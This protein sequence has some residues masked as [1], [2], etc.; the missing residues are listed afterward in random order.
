MASG[1]EQHGPRTLPTVLSSPELLAEWRIRAVESGY[2]QEIEPGTLEGLADAAPVY[3]LAAEDAP[4][5]VRMREFRI[6]TVENPAALSA[7]SGV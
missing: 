1:H 2:I 7:G 5:A 3:A 4:D 6:P